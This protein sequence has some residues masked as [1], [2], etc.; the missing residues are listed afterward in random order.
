[1]AM[2]PSDWTPYYRL[3][4]GELIGYLRPETE[5][6][7]AVT[8]VT[9]FGHPLADEPGEQWWAEQVLED[10][11]LSYLA[12]R[13]ELQRP[14]GGTSRVVIT[15]CSPDRVVVKLAEFAQV[16][17][18][19]PDDLNQQWELSVPTDRLRPA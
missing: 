13:W 19:I 12:E 9:L 8:P 7:D 6:P 18:D 14:D 4:D 17:G 5:T 15:E 1:M 10:L 3:D 11:G 16:V 2:I